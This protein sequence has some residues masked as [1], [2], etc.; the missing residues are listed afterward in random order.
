MFK[1][2]ISAIL[3]LSIAGSLS[4]CE[5]IRKKFTRKKKAKA[6]RPMFYMED[7]DVTRPP[8]EL[9]S[10]HYIFWRSWTND[11]VANA[12]ENAKR[13]R[14]AVGEIIA[15]LTD[16]EK[17]LTGEKKEELRNYIED[18]KVVTD[19]MI[20]GNVNKA[21]MGRLRQELDKISRR[22]SKKF[23]YKKVRDYI[24]KNES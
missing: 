3:V 2:L 24:A 18:T 13:D 15:N 17:Y 6:V 8:A 19:K 21:R 16:M 12:G 14:R 9:Y 11:L 10:M 1:K 20:A 23:Y 5:T 4:G 22:I 7:E